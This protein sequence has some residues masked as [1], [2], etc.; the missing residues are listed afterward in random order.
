MKSQLVLRVVIPFLSTLTTAAMASDIEKL[1]AT[2][3]C[4]HCVIDG[5]NLAG[6]NYAFDSIRNST[7]KNLDLSHSHITIREVFQTELSNINWT[8][9][10]LMVGAIVKSRI[11]SVNFSSSSVHADSL[12]SSTTSDSNFYGADL[13]I[14]VTQSSVL[15]RLGVDSA[16]VAFDRMVDSEIRSVGSQ[17]ANISVA[18]GE[19][20]SIA[21]T[22]L[23]SSEIRVSGRS[24][25]FWKF[26]AKFS[27]LSLLGSSSI[28][29]IQ[30][31][32]LRQSHI[33]TD[34]AVNFPAN[35]NLTG[36]VLNGREC[37]G[38]NVG[39]CY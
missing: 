34:S 6:G 35:N 4:N 15:I 36:A 10:T 39:S 24:I 29:E 31:A 9:S 28:F 22:T 5:A 33:Q 13:S 11:S 19:R 16:S 12:V 8:S 2:G 20:I 1:L 32:D 3:S 14:D 27:S 17:S 37:R 25:K 21:D 7:L 30:G 23:N 18:W 26:V 38:S